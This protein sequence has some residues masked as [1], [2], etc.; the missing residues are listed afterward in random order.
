L[1][2][3][4][5]AMQDAQGALPVLLL[6]DVMSELDPE[7]RGMLLELLSGAG[8]TL[9]TS[10]DEAVLPAGAGSVLRLA[11]PAAEQVP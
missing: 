1:L 7:R 3:E 6:D 9:I 8:Q 10:A 11:A 4:R 2:A 5:D